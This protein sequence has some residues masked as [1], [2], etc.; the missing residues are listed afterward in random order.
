MKL[1]HKVYALLRSPLVLLSETGWF[2]QRV[3]AAALFASN[4]TYSPLRATTCLSC[5]SRCCWT[6]RARFA[7]SMPRPDLG[8]LMRKSRGALG[9]WHCTPRPVPG[10]R[11]A[12]SIEKRKD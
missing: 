5:A 3:T 6:S 12:R 9:P 4:N 8:F 11:Q 10:Y 7:S 2:N 1:G